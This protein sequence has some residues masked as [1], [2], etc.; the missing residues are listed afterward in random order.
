[1]EKIFPICRSITGKG[2]LMTLKLIKKLFTKFKNKEK[3]TFKKQV[4]DW[5]IPEEWNID[6]AYIIDKNHNK[7]IN[8]KTNNLHL[9]NYSTPQ[10]RILSKKTFKKT[11]LFKRLPKCHS[12]RNFLL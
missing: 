5:K 8:F 4:F 2:T 9:V 7:I 6:D 10:S 3:N 1:M 12:I 11:V